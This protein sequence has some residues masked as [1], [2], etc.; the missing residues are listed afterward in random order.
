MATQNNENSND[1]TG[2]YVLNPVPE[3]V[4]DTSRPLFQVHD[5]VVR[6]QGK[7]ILKVDHLTIEHG[8][9]IA[10]LGPNGAGK[11]TL[12]GVLTRQVTPLWR[13]EP[14]ILFC[15]N[16]RPVTADMRRIIGIVSTAMQDQ[17]TVHLPASQVVLG[18]YFGSL[19]VPVNYADFLTDDM[20]EE[21]MDRMRELGCDQLAKRDIRTLSTGQARRVLIA[22]ALV[23]EPQTVVLDEPCA[24]LDPEGIWHVR[25]AV[26]EMAQAGRSII[27]VTHQ[28]EDIQPG[29]DR[30]LLVKNAH[31]VGDGPTSE[32]ITQE[33]MRELFG[34]PVRVSS[35]DDGIYH[36]W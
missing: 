19:G 23:A 33:R 21:A 1:G 27:L 4:K 32:M 3:Y 17:I 7:D 24:G 14:P 30:V 10:I 29:I 28:V 20:R 11:S 16:P 35:T 18:G 31:I 25:Q 9:R 15:G 36:L 34:V 26:E 2:R 13:E 6:R 12:V 8:E 5:A 22:R